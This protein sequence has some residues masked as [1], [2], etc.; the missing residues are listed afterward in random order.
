M[1]ELKMLM[2]IK[3]L[4]LDNNGGFPVLISGKLSRSVGEIMLSYVGKN[5]HDIFNI[6]D[7]FKD[8]SQHKCLELK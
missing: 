7:S 5:I 2:K 1:K 3:K 4:N 6:Q 8:Y